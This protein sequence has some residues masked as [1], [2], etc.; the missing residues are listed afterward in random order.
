MRRLQR[1]PT[2]STGSVRF[3]ERAT[4]PPAWHPDP[5][6]RFEFRYHNGQ[7]WTGDVSIDGHRLVDPLDT[8]PMQPSQQPSAHRL[9]VAALVLSISAIVVGWVPFLC[10]I[11]LAAAVLAFVFGLVALRRC[12][13]GAD[14]S[15]RGLALAGVILAPFGLAVS[16]LGKT[17]GLQGRTS[18]GS[19]PG[20]TSVETELLPT[21]PLFEAFEKA[22]RFSLEAV[23]HKSVFPLLD[24]DVAG[25]IK[26]CQST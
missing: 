1:S 25:L 12:R 7:A 11:A 10:A 19:E 21:D 6:N 17:Y 5:T 18:I 13:R 4:T 3:V 8:G 23:G 9:A 22:D 15:R 20:A 26:L 16:V 2:N 14:P 24:A